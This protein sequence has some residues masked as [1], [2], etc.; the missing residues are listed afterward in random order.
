MQFPV[1]FGPAADVVLANE[2]LADALRAVEG[3]LRHVGDG[4]AQHL[5]FQQHAHFEH[6]RQFRVGN[7]RDHCPAIALEHHQA[8]SL[9]ALEGLAHRNLAD[10][11][12]PG[13]V[14]LTNRL[15]LGEVPGDD[16]VTQVASDDFRR[17]RRVAEVGSVESG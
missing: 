15:V 13:N 17:R 5:V 2:F 8:F 3:V 11:E 12:L 16:G 10:V 9:Q 6:L 14:V 4:Q 7:P 1:E